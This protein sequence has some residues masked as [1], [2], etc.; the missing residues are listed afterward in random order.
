M[1]SNN[2]GRFQWPIPPWNADWQKWQAEFKNFASGVDSTVFAL[3]EHLTIIHHTLP[4]V[5]IT[6]PAPTEYYFSQAGVT[7][8]MSRTMQV[9]IEVGPTPGLGLALT[10]GGLIGAS[11]QPGA[12]GPQAVD[13]ELYTSQT[14]IDASVMI[15]GI[16]NSNYSITWFNGNVLAVLD[17]GILFAP[18]VAGVGGETVKVTGADPMAHYLNT[19]IVAGP[20]ITK[21]ILPPGGTG[22]SLEISAAGPGAV[23]TGVGNP[24]GVQVGTRGQIYEDI[25]VP[26]A[27]LFYINTSG[28]MVWNVF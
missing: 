6:H 16:V 15:F 27:E 5:T 10:A 9:Q 20:N 28:A 14:D 21:A 18:I 7:R 23:L 4:V 11:I 24:N 26:G 13:W 1:A 25:A 2:T 8:F 17:V 3:L 19:K 22:E 12:I